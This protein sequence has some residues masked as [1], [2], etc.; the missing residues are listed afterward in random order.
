MS[1]TFDRESGK[2]VALPETVEKSGG[3]QNFRNFLTGELVSGAGQQSLKQ[4]YRR[5]TWVMAAI[6]YT[7]LPISSVGLEWQQGGEDVEDDA[8]DDFWAQPAEE[9]GGRVSSSDL[10]KNSVGWYKLKGEFFWILDDSWLG[11]G[12]L[13]SKSPI[14]LVRPDEMRQVCDRATGELVAWQYLCRDGK[15]KHWADLLPEQV[16]HK[17]AWNPYCRYRG[18]AEFEAAELAAETDYSA[19]TFSKAVMDSNGD[20]GPTVTGDGE[21]SDEQYEQIVTAMREKRERNRR[22]DFRP[23]FLVGNNLKVNDPTIQ[24][25]DAQMIANREWNRDEIFTAFGV[26]ASFAQ[27]TASYSVGS[28][29]DRFKNI[30]ENARPMGYVIAEAMAE[31]MNSSGLRPAVSEAQGGMMRASFNWDDHTT[32]QEVRSERI[33]VGA[34]LVDRGLSWSVVNAYLNLG[35]PSFD[36]DDVR[37]VPFNVREVSETEYLRK[38]AT[39]SSPAEKAELD[40][41]FDGI[42]KALE[43]RPKP[44]PRTEAA[45]RVQ[46]VECEVCKIDGDPE[47]GKEPDPRWTAQRRLR[48][49]WERRLKSRFSRLL[50]SARSETL[51]LLEDAGRIEVPE[52]ETFSKSFQQEEKMGILDLLFN[53]PEWL[54]SFLSGIGEVERALITQSSLDTWE[55]LGLDDDPLELPE[56]VVITTLRKR[57]NFLIDAAEGIHANILATLEEGLN[58]G[59]TFDELTAR[60]RSAF[61][62]INEV[63]AERIARTE[64]TAVYEAGR[65]ATFEAAGVEFKEWLTSGLDNVRASHFVTN[66]QV[67]RTGRKFR[68]GGAELAHPGDSNGP[69]QEVINCNCVTIASIGPESDGDE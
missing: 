4:A 7:F 30:E 57:E 25:A 22:G 10:I 32:M 44:M 19:G 3:D 13:A 47:L 51:R 59:E 41:V 49:E 11:I 40:E 6:R 9:C 33:E 28:A 46:P 48:G 24:S 43:M 66:G 26:P 53:L 60:V 55:E 64:V 56:R 39:G 42:T 37:R 21:I 67:V 12:P 45:P 54:T 20:M 62:G 68:V 69:A 8:V 52:G 18:L 58:E 17:K 15:S 36:G 23:L 14:L 34:K 1:L 63:R 16:I 65:Q 35:L 50:M 5:S 2:M 31:V 27:A 38:I 29:S 61:N